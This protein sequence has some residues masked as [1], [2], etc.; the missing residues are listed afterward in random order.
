MEE[1]NLN[2][3]LEQ[4]EQLKKIGERLYEIR[5]EKGVSLETI[6]E[7]TMISKRLLKA[8]DKGDFVELPE[9]F[10][11]KALMVKYGR[12]L[13]AMDIVDSLQTKPVVVAGDRVEKVKSAPQSSN[14]RSFQINWQLNS[15]HLYIVYIVLII[16]AVRGLASLVEPS[17]TVVTQTTEE[18]TSPVNNQQ[19]NTSLNK[20][21]PQ[22]ISQ[23]T[24]TNSVIVGINLQDRCWLKVMVDGKLAFEGILPQGT[25]K[26]WE[27]QEEVTI[28]A[29]N[30][31]GVVVTFNN[32]Q[33][34]ILGKP[35]EV[36]E[37]TYT[38]N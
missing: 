7:Q 37:V 14:S 11:T 31:G 34:K 20:G 13:N 33:K 26:T 16:I 22:L 9:L 29:G 38:V 25:Q 27:G 17:T 5:M 36:E 2:S 8:I 35:G 6:S 12:A 15:L 23:S 28:R 1:N 19:P 4:Q 3:Q 30:A 18:K 24:D 21:L 32:G 10:Y